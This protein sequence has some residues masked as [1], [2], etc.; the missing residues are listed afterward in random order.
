MLMAV[1]MPASSVGGTD[2][3]AYMQA[4]VAAV[5]TVL[6]IR[7]DLASTA[8]ALLR[9]DPAVAAPVPRHGALADSRDA[10]SG[11]PQPWVL[12]LTAAALV[13]YVT[14]RRGLPRP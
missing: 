8:P 6:T 2:D 9:R 10:S 5:Q 14:G 4:P 7:P 12:L 13:V 11:E 1:S 3:A